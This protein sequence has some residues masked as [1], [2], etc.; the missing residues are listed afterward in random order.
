MKH[1]NFAEGKFE[2]FFECFISG[3][4]DFGDYFDH[5]LSWY[6]H[7]NE[8][9][10]LFLTYEEM[11]DNIEISLL[12]IITFLGKKYT[13]KLNNKQIL[14]KIIEQSS[15]ENMSKNQQ[16][17]SS[18]RPNNMPPFVRKGKVGDWKNYFSREQVKRLKDKFVSRTMGTDLEK[19][20]I[21]IV[22]N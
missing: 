12:K 21:N 14:N 22:S 11:K 15:F 1:Y 3:E 10:V 17:W 6:Q 4:V 9:N 19:L 13:E 7:K 2:D 16:R 20:W 5:L 8:P 18:K